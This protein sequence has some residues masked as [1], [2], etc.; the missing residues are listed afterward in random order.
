MPHRAPSANGQTPRC[1]VQ[2]VGR[3]TVGSVYVHGAA[4]LSS[5]ANT[6]KQS[7][8]RS[9]ETICIVLMSYHSLCRGYWPA[10]GK[11]DRSASGWDQIGQAG[12]VTPG[13]NAGI[14]SAARQSAAIRH[15]AKPRAKCNACCPLPLPISSTQAGNGE[16]LRNTADSAP[17]CARK[18]AKTVSYIVLWWIIM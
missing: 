16:N 9:H 10:I 15:A 3:V 12:L 17:C 14:F 18:M 13:G 1:W 2:A 5:P 6:G 4:G 11:K 7:F 8:H